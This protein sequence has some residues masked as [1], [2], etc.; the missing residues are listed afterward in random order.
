MWMLVFLANDSIIQSTTFVQTEIA[1]QQDICVLL[2]INY[3][4]P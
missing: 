3:Y 1:Q 4:Y 2:R